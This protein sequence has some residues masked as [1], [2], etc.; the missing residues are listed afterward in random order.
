MFKKQPNR[1]PF[2]GGLVLFSLV[3]FFLPNQQNV[4]ADATNPCDLVTYASGYKDQEI[5]LLNS[6]IDVGIMSK[7]G[8]ST[9]LTFNPPFVPQIGPY[10]P[11]PATF[12]TTFSNAYHCPS[13]VEDRTAPFYVITPVGKFA[14]SSDSVA[15]VGTQKTLPVFPFFVDSGLQ[16][17]DFGIWFSGQ[18]RSDGDCKGNQL[19]LTLYN[20]FLNNPS[21][22]R[23]VKSASGSFSNLDIA[24]EDAIIESIAAS[25]NISIG[26]SRMIYCLIIREQYM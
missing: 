16:F 24:A 5:S 6:K 14:A 23:T 19:C 13:D 11:P 7:G 12:H 22:E 17:H 18:Y 8:D 21:I 25:G 9:I 4:F 3:F 26:K 15:S 10:Q 1:A 20:F 2:Y